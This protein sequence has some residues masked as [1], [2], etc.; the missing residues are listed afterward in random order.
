MTK[1]EQLG[2]FPIVANND[3]TRLFVERISA[4]KAMDEYA[5]QQAIAFDTWKRNNKWSDAM[6]EGVYIKP[7]GTH[8]SIGFKFEKASFEYLYGQF[9]EQQNKGK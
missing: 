4:L 1:E 5:K 6:D 2:K 3:G 8:G 9:I 7:I